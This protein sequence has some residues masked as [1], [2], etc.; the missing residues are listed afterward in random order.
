VEGED[1]D[2][3]G[4]LGSLPHPRREAVAGEGGEAMAPAEL[5]G[6]QA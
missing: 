5:G 3:R 1:L 6:E 4:D 2:Q